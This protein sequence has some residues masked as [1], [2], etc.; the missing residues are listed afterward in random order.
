MDRKLLDNKRIH[1]RDERIEPKDD[2]DIFKDN[3]QT[4]EKRKNAQN[5]EEKITNLLEVLSTTIN[6]YF[7]KFN[8]WLD[9]LTD[10]RKQHSITYDKKSLIWT[11]LILM[12]TKQGSRK[13]IT[14][15]FRS[16]ISSV[17]LKEFSGQFNLE[18]VP[19][20]DTVEYFNLRSKEEELQN[21]QVKIMRSLFKK[22]ALEKYRLQNKY[23]TVAIDGYHLYT[24]D[25]PHCKHCL[26]KEDE[27][28]KKYWFHYKLQASLV[29]PTGLCLPL[30]SV[31]IENEPEYNKQDCELKAFYRLIKKLRILYSYL[32]ICVLL[33]GLY[34]VEPVFNLLEKNNIE[35]IIVF[36]EGRMRQVYK[37]LINWKK[38]F[39]KDNSLIKK[40]QKE[41]PLRNNRTSKDKFLRNKPKYKTRSATTETTYSWMDNIE[42]WNP[43]NK[44][45]YNIMTNQETENNTTKCNY[46]WLVSKG[47][48]LNKETVKELAERGRCRWVIENQG[49]NMQ[50][51]GGYNLGHCYSKDPASMKVWARII[52]I[53][54]IINQLIE[55]GSLIAIKTYGS[56]RNIASRMF[57]HFRYFTFKKLDTRPKI[58]IR[59]CWDTS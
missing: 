48:N 10:V 59:L 24:F 38:R 47:L 21:L 29:T 53:A 2:Q 18:N 56:I 8:D 7:P 14:D 4:K 42:Y 51:N 34:A 54:C 25:Y 22:R 13:R 19:H 1:K 11:A 52:D 37:W 16:K 45:K 15:S 49:I 27:N 39:A 31:W 40:T 41:I 46:V 44:R 3:R 12:L 55:K 33:D 35:W 30:A 26:S 23:H 5:K 28:G 50:K 6:H 32:P 57:E 9:N 20:G 58:Q 43:D 17:N 36:K